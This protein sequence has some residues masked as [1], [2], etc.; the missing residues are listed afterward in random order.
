M[1]GLC[2]FRYARRSKALDRGFVLGVCVCVYVCTRARCRVVGDRGRGHIHTPKDHPPS[3]P[4]A[5]SFCR[6]ANTLHV[7]I[8][9]ANLAA[10]TVTEGVEPSRRE[11]VTVHPGCTA[12]LSYLQNSPWFSDN[13]EYGP[14][15]LLV[16]HLRTDSLQHTKKNGYIVQPAWLS[17]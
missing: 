5:K 17:G 14:Q 3:K 16:P 10:Q 15:G 2:H 12:S 8:S 7:E 6:T 11:L 4:V 13:N 9:K 1:Q